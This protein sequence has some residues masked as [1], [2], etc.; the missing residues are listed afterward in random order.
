MFGTRIRE[1]RLQKGYSQKDL[2]K[3]L[4]VN[5]RTVSRWEQNTNRP[6]PEELGKI[7]KLIGISEEELFTDTTEDSDHYYDYKHNI[8]DRISDSVDNLVTGQENI[9]GSL[10]SNRDEFIRKQDEVIKELKSQNE[11][12]LV[13][14]SSY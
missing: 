5:V 9:N 12:L 13:Q 2:A 8:L 11:T 6:N 7:A 4:D 1:F 14:I 3:L 10:L